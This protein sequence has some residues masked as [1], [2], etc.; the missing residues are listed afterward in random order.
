MVE[1][2]ARGRFQAGNRA[3]KGNPYIQRVAALRKALYECVTPEDMRALIDVLKKKALD[4]DVKAITLLLDRLLGP[5]VALDVWERL[6][7]L[8]KLAEKI[9]ADATENE[10]S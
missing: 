2:D 3:G 5:S 8:E 1:R 4:G 9:D 7:K 10:P 6:E